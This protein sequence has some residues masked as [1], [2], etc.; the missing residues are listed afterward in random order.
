[1]HLVVI[2]HACVT[3]INQ[4]IYAEMEKMGHKIDLIVPSNF[5]AKGLTDKPISVKRWPGFSGRILQIPIYF[6]K[7]IPLHFYKKRFKQFFEN[8]RPDA[9]YVAEE[10]YSLSCFQILKSALQ[11]T[12]AIG[13]YSAQNI[14]KDYPFLFRK[15]ERYVY[16]H[17]SLAV[18]ISKDVTAVLRDKG[19]QKHICQVPLGVDEDHFHIS[20]DLRAEARREA[21]IPSNSFVIGFAGRLVKE[22]GVD[23]LIK[24]FKSIYKEIS[25]MYVLIVGRGPLISELKKLATELGVEENIVF[26][27]NA[28]HSE[29]PKWFNGMDVQVLPSITMPNWREQFGRVLIEA[30]ACGVP[31]I[32]S[33]SGEIPIVLDSLG[34]ENVFEEGNINQLGNEIIRLAQKTRNSS[35]IREFSIDKYGNKGIAAKL[36]S[37]FEKVM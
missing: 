12:K 37:A 19:Y 20:E 27:N 21:N 17:S 18:S 9:V 14:K 31:S 22:K 23:L 13:F 3:D 8:N 36:V 15:M 16:E 2:S 30:A 7:S 1:M 5:I 10:P 33:S 24:A 25:N 29:M 35:D 4:Q 34:M 28:I 11:Y 6:N 26:I 32:G